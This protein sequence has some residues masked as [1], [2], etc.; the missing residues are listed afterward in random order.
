MKVY[1]AWHKNNS[2]RGSS[3]SGGVF[4]ALAEYVL[5]NKGYVCGAVMDY[6]GDT[7]KVKHI[8]T[9][10][11]SEI[12]RM[13]GS[14]YVQSE[15]GKNYKHIKDILQQNESNVLFSGTPCQ[16]AGLKRY[17]GKLAN[18]RLI[19]V[20]VLCHGVSSPLIFEEY[21]KVQQQSFG[22]KI[23]KINFRYK[24]PGWIVFSIYEEF[25]NGAKYMRDK[26]TDAY[27]IG[28]LNDMY[29]RRSCMKCP[30]TSLN[31]KGDFTLADFWG[32]K[33]ESFAMRNNEKG[34][35]IVIVNT[36][37][38][39]V[40]WK[41]IQSELI[42]EEHPV[43]DILGGNRSFQKPWDRNMQS[44]EFWNTYHT[45]GWIAASEKY[46]LPEKLS[47]KAKINFLVY[48]YWYLIP[49]GLIRLMKEVLR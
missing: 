49:K 39:S 15:M 10:K 1:G 2:I 30:Y 9:N 44:E 34:I 41:V 12:K 14:K 36:D 7:P 35:S 27:L 22:A 23:S 32:Y 19:T 45:N 47:I 29:A 24:K 13:R 16:V 11:Y 26:F 20:D 48:R 28:F 17:L 40:I 21:C 37:R 8:I 43:K 31:R 5:K 25:E 46:C 33:S 4:S 38:A 42:Y 18:D 6:S 3:T